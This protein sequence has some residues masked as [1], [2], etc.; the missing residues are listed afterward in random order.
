MWTTWWITGCGRFFVTGRAVLPAQGIFRKGLQMGVADSDVRPDVGLDPL[1]DAERLWTDI[2]DYVKP[3]VSREGFETW[4]APTRGCAT[5]NGVLEVEVPN[6]FFADWLSQHYSAEVRAALASVSSRELSVSF[7]PRDAADTGVLIR[8]APVRRPAARQNGYRLQ[9]HLSFENFVVGESNRLA[10]A[11][12][13][14]VAERPGVNYNP[15]F[16]Y[17]GVGLGK[18]HLA[19]AIG[20][21]AL[22]AKPSLKVY[23]TAA[24][25]L[26]LELIQAIEKNTRIDFKN[27]YRGLDLLLL[28]DVHYLVGKERLQEEVFYIF[29]SLH[30]A[31]SQIVFTSDR[32]PQDIPALEGRLTSRLGS[33]LVVDIQ[34]PELETRIAILKQKAAM[35]KA[36]LPDDVAYFIAARVRTSVRALAGSWIRLLA[37]AS[38]D[39]RPITTALAEEALRDLIKEEEPVDHSRIIKACAEHFGVTLKDITNGGR[40]KQL[41]LARQ[42]AMYLLRAALNLSLKEIGGLFGNKDHTTVMHALKRVSELKSSDPAFAARLDKLSKGISRGE[43]R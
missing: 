36:E 6:S 7:R 24:D 4:L 38:L 20:N 31:G 27:K 21:S 12:A 32:P 1:P 25:D 28:D 26:F 15:L 13:R 39:D 33:G 42:V 3:R 37:L 35:D 14:S 23:Y 5:A 2:L 19:Q 11:A 10:V 9:S 29:N 17:G 43:Q 16:I 22:A 18:T 30:D 41:A 40:T 34:P 8:R